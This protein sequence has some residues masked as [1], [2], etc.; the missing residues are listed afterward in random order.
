MTH[1]FLNSDNGRGNAQ[2]CNKASFETRKYA[3]K[4]LNRMGK[5]KGMLVASK[6]TG[7]MRVYRCDACRLYHLGHA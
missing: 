7:A 2:A 1:A 6:P 4:A 5:N 3:L